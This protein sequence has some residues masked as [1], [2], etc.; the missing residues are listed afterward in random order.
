MQKAGTIVALASATAYI[1]HLAMNQPS[2][3]VASILSEEIPYETEMRFIQYLAEHGKSY[4]TKEEFEFRLQHFADIDAEINEHNSENGLFTMG[5]NK[6]SDMTE[7]EKAVYRGRKGATTYSDD[8]DE[9]IPEFTGSVA[10]SVDW[11]K[12]GPVNKIKDQG[13]CGSCWTFSGIG[14]IEAAHY[15]KTG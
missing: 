9:E 15:F 12:K 8:E 2:N 7:A 5:H 10:S 14:V 3:K 6:F 4:G 13:N 11:R 1:G